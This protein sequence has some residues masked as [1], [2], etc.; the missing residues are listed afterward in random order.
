MLPTAVRDNMFRPLREHTETALQL[1]CHSLRG[2]VAEK[3]PSFA[4]LFLAL[5]WES[6]RNMQF[7]SPRW[8]SHAAKKCRDK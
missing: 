7:N 8:F 1:F 3:I 5:L 6:P 2:A 4:A